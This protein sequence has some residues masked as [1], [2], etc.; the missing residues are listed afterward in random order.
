[1]NIEIYIIRVLL[2]REL[3]I[4][5]RKYVVLSK[6]SSKDLLSLYQLLDNMHQELQRDISLNEFC[7]NVEQKQL[8]ELLPP[9]QDSSV[10]D[11]TIESLLEKLVAKQWAYEHACLAVEVHEGKKDIDALLEHVF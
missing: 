9:L 8:Q 7:L 10:P 6:D 3:Y 4:K 11:D 5:Y 2:Q 1:M